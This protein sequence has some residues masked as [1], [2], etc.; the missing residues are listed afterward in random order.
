MNSNP[1]LDELYRARDEYA[2]SFNYDLAAIANDARAHQGEDGREV[3][4]FPP[5]RP[6]HWN[7]K[8]EVSTAIAEF[9][10]T[11]GGSTLDLEPELEANSLIVSSE[12]Q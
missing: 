1:I 9:A 8:A 7:D 2:A 10:A 3:V 4:S 11:H 12:T 6:K 5:R